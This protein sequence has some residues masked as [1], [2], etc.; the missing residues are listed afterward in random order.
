MAKINGEGNFDSALEV[1]N[2]LVYNPDNKGIDSKFKINIES[3]PDSIW[4][5]IQFN[6]WWKSPATYNAILELFK[7][8][9]KSWEN[10]RNIQLWSSNNLIEI[11]LDKNWSLIIST[12]PQTISISKDEISKKINTRLR[13]LQKAI[14]IDIMLNPE[15]IEEPILQEEI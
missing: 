4:N 5:S 12:K 8:W 7:V 6:Q 2:S 3:D 14:T 13:R 1:Q 9:E 15:E 10:I 11:F